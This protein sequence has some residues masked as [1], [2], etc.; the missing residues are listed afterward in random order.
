MDQ[1]SLTPPKTTYLPIFIGRQTIYD[2]RLNVWGYELL[3]RSS[4]NDNVAQF[5]DP[6]QA[7]A[8]VITEGFSM[9][10]ESIPKGRK[11]FINYPT[12]LLLKNAPLALPKENC[13][14]EVLETVKPN[15]EIIA[16][17]STLKDNGYTIAL[18]DYVGQPGYDPLLELADIIKVEFLG[19]PWTELIKIGQKLHKY[20]CL[21]LAEKVEN[22]PTLEL[23]ASLGFS[24][25]QGFFFSRPEII[26]GRTIPTAVVNRIRLIHEINAK[27]FEV[28]QVAKI[29]SQDPGLSFRLL[30][31]I[32]SVFYS[33]RHNVRS[34]SQAVTLMGSRAIKQWAM[35]SMLA[36]IGSEGKNQELLFSSVHRARFLEIL[37]VEANQRKHDPDTMFL[38]GLFSNLDAMLNLPMEDILIHLP[39]EKDIG[40]ALRGEDN[41][42]RQWIKMTIAVE[43]GDWTSVV[44]MIDFFRLDEQKTAMNHLRAADWAYKMLFAQQ[45]TENPSLK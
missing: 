22:R 29:I 34:I 23:A 28:S 10:T 16:S 44:S 1:A 15:P 19:R 11:I 14:I 45:A 13:V 31:H 37:A 41:F 24:Y 33:F 6:E 30:K 3:F 40:A 21:L 17:L 42:M 5:S 38:L 32:N 39:L 2:N 27:D 35:L 18:D 26:T 20:R 43:R 7:T 8:M 4:G 25:F 9:A 36:D 12:G